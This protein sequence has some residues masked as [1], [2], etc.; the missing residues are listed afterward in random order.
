MGLGAGFS[1]VIITSSFSL[2]FYGAGAG[3]SSWTIIGFSSFGFF[4]SY[5]TGAAVAVVVVLADWLFY[6]ADFLTASFLAISF[7]QSFKI[8]EIILSEGDALFALRRKSIAFS[9]FLSP[10]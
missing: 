5:T 1:S 6:S 8:P 10:K 4:S 3:F 7:S 9:Y 2:G